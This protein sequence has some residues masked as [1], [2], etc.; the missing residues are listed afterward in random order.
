MFS[1]GD[2]FGLLMGRECAVFFFSIFYGEFWIEDLVLSLF[3][4]LELRNS[5]SCSCWGW[6]I[7]YWGVEL[8]GVGE[9]GSRK[10]VTK[11]IVFSRCLRLYY[12]EIF[13]NGK[14]IRFL[15]IVLIDMIYMIKSVL[16]SNCYYLL[17]EDLLSCMVFLGFF[18]FYILF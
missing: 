1:R 16:K 8:V 5:S 13:C 15:M 3:F 11:L 7:I 18:K 14:N 4:S 6:G 2:E 10:E 17:K 9:V 12:M